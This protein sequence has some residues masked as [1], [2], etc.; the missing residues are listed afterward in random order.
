MGRHYCELCSVL[1]EDYGDVEW[2]SCQNSYCPAEGEQIC[3]QC[4]DTSQG[5]CS[6]CDNTCSM[7][8][9]VGP[10]IRKPGS[11]NYQSDLAA[12]CECGDCP[13]DLLL[14]Y[15]DTCLSCFERIAEDELGCDVWGE[16]RD[17]TIEKC[18]HHVCEAMQRQL[19]C[20]DD[21]ECSVCKEE[22]EYKVV[23]KERESEA[24]KVQSDV[25]VMRECLA[26]VES[27]SARSVLE[28]WLKEHLPASQETTGNAISGAANSRKSRLKQG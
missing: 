7:C 15:R 22:E 9:L 14:A 1:L 18:G 10:H 19:K 13:V 5:V 3:C 17:W 24:A 2:N 8:W 20:K 26:K 25:S 21:T 4:A 23:K 16:H 6:Q 28:S 12:E 11:D 27:N